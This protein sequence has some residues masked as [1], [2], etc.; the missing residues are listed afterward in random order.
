M[1]IE[2]ENDVTPAVLKAMEKAPDARIREIAASFVKHM[3]AFARDVRLT[4]REWEYGVGMLNR[5]GPLTNDAHNEGILFSDTIGLS[6]LVTLMNNGANGSTETAA[7][8]LGP[9]WRMHSPETASGGSIVRSATPGPALFASCRV[10]D[11][12]GKPVANA[13]VDVWHASPTGMYENQEEAQADH[14]LRG[15]FHTDAEGRFAFRSVLPAGYPIPTGGPA[16][17]MV[18]YQKREPWRPAHLHFLIYKPGFKTL[19]TQVF[20]QGAKYLDCDVVFGVT[21]A[22]IGDYKQHESGTPPAA[23]VKAPWYTLDYTFHVEP[24]EANLPTPPIK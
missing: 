24:G 7:A 11:A 8:L 13:E 19:V 12:A 17:E 20:V 5:I 15:K 3:H 4:E 21:R 14:N 1:I 18:L 16:G 9:F 6:T 10:V 23:D 2:T 22:L